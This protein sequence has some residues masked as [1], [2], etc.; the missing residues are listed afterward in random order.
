[1]NK[2]KLFV[3]AVLIVALVLGLIFCWLYGLDNDHELL[4]NKYWPLILFAPFLGLLVAGFTKRYDPRI[5][6]DEVLRHDSAAILEH[7]AHALGTLILL[8][9]GIAL[10]FFFIPNVLSMRF[11]SAMM[12]VHFAGS[13]LFLFGSFYYL[14][15]SLYA[16][17]RVKEHLPTRDALKFIVQHYGARIGIKKYALPPEKKYLESEKIAY[18]F[19]IASVVLVLISGLF[20]AAA[21]MIDLPESL[22]VVMTMIHDIGAILVVLFFV[23]HVFFAAIA[24]GTRPIFRSMFTGNIPLEVVEKEHAGW[25]QKLKTQDDEQVETDE[26]GSSVGKGQLTREGGMG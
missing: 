15:N 23:A 21:H 9:S 11:N 7:W 6:G 18:V 3:S 19:A 12:N 25:L 14:G 22:M 26:E 10:G 1:M 5:I 16:K 13:L 4:L 2:N 20:K 17:N 24:P 8:I